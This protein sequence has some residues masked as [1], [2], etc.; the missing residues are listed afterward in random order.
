MRSIGEGMET[1]AAG[2]SGNVAVKSCGDVAIHEAD[3]PNRPKDEALRWLISL[4]EEPDDAALAA[5][6]EA[7]LAHSEANGRAWA[8]ARHV[9]GVL[10]AAE[11]AL[12]RRH[13][14]REAARA[15]GGRPAVRRRGRRVAAS[16][17][18][19]VALFVLV[20]LQPAI[21]IWMMAD[22]AT[23][24]AETRAVGLDDGSVAWLGADSAIQVSFDKAARRVTLLSGEAYFEVQRDAGRPFRVSADGVTA[25]VLGTAFDVR[26][27]PD[28][29][30]VAVS[31]GK[32][33]VASARAPAMAGDQ[34][35]AGD[36]ISIDNAGRA[37]RGT[38]D[39][40]L[41]GGWRSG[42]LVVQDRPVAEVVQV[43]G[44]YQR[45]RIV[46]AGSGLATRR[47]TGIYDLNAPAEALL[48]VAETHGATVRRIS[49]WL[50]V[51][52]GW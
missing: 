19:I 21:T 36:W 1:Q 34:L 17:M 27:D 15:K 14:A 20:L 30:S 4:Q 40:E 37:E 43:L 2:S 51:V 6:F 18:G 45:G 13:G 26:T 25:T 50:T 29:V 35:E 11:P 39:P 47:V 8:E 32:V 5:R 10:G 48:A 23:G 3:D 24:V 9:W 12:E 38:A 22:H 49:P 44:R 7:W 41:A 46:I 33:A 52:S 31:H 28:S 42:V 16:A